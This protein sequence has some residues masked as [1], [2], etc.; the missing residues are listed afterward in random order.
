MESSSR[1]RNLAMLCHLSSF[2]MI[3]VP[4]G[5]VLGPALVWALGREKYPLVD[6]QGKESM[7]FQLS[8]AIYSLVS[9]VLMAV[10][11][12]VF[13]LAVV[14]LFCLINVIRAAISANNGEKFRYPLCIRLIK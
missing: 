14:V 8:I 4:F 10:L 11:I 5:N 7:N 12:G 2:L 9:V 6:D 3:I 1:E 13:L